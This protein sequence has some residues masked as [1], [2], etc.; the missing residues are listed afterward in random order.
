MFAEELEFLLSKRVIY[1]I[2]L[3]GTRLCSQIF[4]DHEENGHLGPVL[5][6]YKPCQY[7]KEQ[8]F[9]KNTVISIFRMI[10]RMHY[11][12]SLDIKKAIM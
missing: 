3:R 12:T 11:F 9:N 1:D 8:R 2:H 7:V 10:R 5:D 4:Y 6:I